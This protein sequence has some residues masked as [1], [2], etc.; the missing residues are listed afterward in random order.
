[1]NADGSTETGSLID[2]IVREGAR[3]MLVAALEAEVDAYIAELARRRM[4]A[5]GGSWSATAITSPER[6]PPRPGRS[7]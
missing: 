7:Q 2:D 3:R 1:M 6:S 5:G 4:N